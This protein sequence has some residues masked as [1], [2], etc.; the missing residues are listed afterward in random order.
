MAEVQRLVELPLPR[1][2]VAAAALVA[3]GATR[4]PEVH[5]AVGA[6]TQR[7]EGAIEEAAA[8]IFALSAEPPGIQPATRARTQLSGLRRGDFSALV[9]DLLVVGNV[10]V[11]H[12]APASYARAAAQTAGSAVKRAED[13]KVAEFQRG[14]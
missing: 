7:V 1:Q 10:V 8:A 3:P 13:G 5:G 9:S 11:T 14:L 4:A 12:P 2:S 6:G